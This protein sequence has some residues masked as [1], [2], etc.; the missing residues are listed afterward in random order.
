MISTTLIDRQ[1][2]LARQNEILQT[3]KQYRQTKKFDVRWLKLSNLFSGRRLRSKR[4]LSP[5]PIKRR[6]YSSR[7]R[8]TNE[9]E[10]AVIGYK[11]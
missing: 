8:Q 1:N 10:T 4:P 6:K 3:T 11:I 2:V 9:M 7:R 5:K